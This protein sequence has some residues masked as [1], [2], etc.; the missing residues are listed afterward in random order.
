MRISF[1]LMG[2]SSLGF[3]TL[4]YRSIPPL[5]NCTPQ[6]RPTQLR[7]GEDAKSG[8]WGG[9]ET[10]RG[11][12][13]TLR[14]SGGGLA[15]RRCCGGGGGG[16]GGKPAGEEG[17]RRALY[18]RRLGSARGTRSRASRVFACGVTKLP[19]LELEVALSTAGSPLAVSG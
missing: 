4:W 13:V 12:A 8:A 7:S 3:S 16:G 9:G 10:V 2:A 5:L 6:C 18:G 15:R 19:P 14:S 1:S 11:G 17:R